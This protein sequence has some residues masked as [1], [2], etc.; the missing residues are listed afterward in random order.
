METQT[1]RTTSEDT[2]QLIRAEVLPKLIEMQGK[3]DVTNMKLSSIEKGLCNT[4]ETVQMLRK[5][6]FGNG[7]QEQDGLIISVAK[8]KDWIDARS[9]YEKLIITTIVIELFGLIF[10]FIRDAVI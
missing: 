3:L 6:L 7:N 9:A 4:D 8:I 1:H 10:L 2:V 5:T